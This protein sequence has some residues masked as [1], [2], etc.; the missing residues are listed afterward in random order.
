MC[1]ESQ[2]DTKVTNPLKDIVISILFRTASTFLRFCSMRTRLKWTRRRRRERR[3]P[4][5]T[6]LSR[7]NRRRAG[8]LLESEVRHCLSHKYSQDDLLQSSVTTR[9]SPMRCSSS[10]PATKQPQRR[11]RSLPIYS[12]CIRTRK[13]SCVR[14]SMTCGSNVRLV[15]S[16]VLL[17]T[18]IPRAISPTTLLQPVMGLFYIRMITVCVTLIHL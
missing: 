5:W 14:K 17:Y 8:T 12:P 10:W 16:N 11:R 7:R 2:Q 13:R 6:T 9:L 1:K 18:I 4:P 15:A 3:H